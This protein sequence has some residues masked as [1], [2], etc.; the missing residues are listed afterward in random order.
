MSAPLS[1]K[2]SS[3]MHPIAYVKAEGYKAW[4]KKQ[5][6]RMQAWLEVQDFKPKAG[7]FILLPSKEGALER[8]LVIGSDTPSL[9]D[10]SAA[11]ASLPKGMFKLDGNDDPQVLEKLYLGWILGGHQPERM[12]SKA[13]PQPAARLYAPCQSAAKAAQRMADAILQVRD[14]ISAP[15]NKLGP[16]ELVA[17]AKDTLAGEGVEWTEI[18]GEALLTQNYPAIHAVGRAST[19]A[20]RLIDIRWGR[21]K[22][23]MVTLVGKGVVYDTGGL[24]IKPSSAMYLMRKDMGGA[25]VALGVARMIVAAK[26]PVRLRLLLPVVENAV[27]GNAYR[28]SDVLTMR[29]GQTVEVGNTDAEGRLILADALAE[30]ASEK[31]AL[32]IDFSTL[33]GA[34]RAAVGT[35][36]SAFFTDDKSLA[37]DLE[38]AGED[39]QD[40]VWR[41]P[42]FDGY[43]DMLRSSFADM[44]SCPASPYA[45]AITAALF[46]RR[47]VGKT[48][49]WIHFDF[50]AWNMSSRAGR[51]EGGEA[52]ALRAVYGLLA[53]RFGGKSPK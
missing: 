46:L 2:P 21:A 19:R 50:M 27:S 25:A 22:D 26:L 42:L 17:A 23:P 24:D 14:L 1:A 53:K 37:A 48:I 9:W 13:D 39:T 6:A 4:V 28:A 49:P 45:G 51:P 11:A 32:L 36:I 44:N 7:A 16:D 20:P 52:M 10:L 40:P 41:L 43:D 29:D 5:P 18:V 15:A 30:A 8:V 3:V 31:P 35:G 38:A 47:F 34:A 12:K 33:T